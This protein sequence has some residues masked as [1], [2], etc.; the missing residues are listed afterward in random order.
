MQVTIFGVQQSLDILHIRLCL[1][2]LGLAGFGAGVLRRKK[3]TVHL[4]LPRD[5]SVHFAVHGAALISRA[6]RKAYGWR[7]VL[8]RS[9]EFR[10]PRDP[11]LILRPQQLQQMPLR[12]SFSPTSCPQLFIGTWNVE[13]LN[14]A[15]KQQKIGCMLLSRGLHI[16]AVQES[17]ERLSSCIAVPGFR[18]FGRPCIGQ[19]EGGVGSLSRLHL[20]RRLR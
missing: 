13:G 16:V 12:P 2:D 4:S 19:S 8:H 1:T 7:C 6:L 11:R 3:T 17:H 14:S 10:P 15:C 18:W 20:C 9:D 5:V